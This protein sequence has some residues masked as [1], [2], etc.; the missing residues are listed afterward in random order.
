MGDVV[1]IRPP[2]CRCGWKLPMMPFNINMVG[3]I[4]SFEG[5]PI[6]ASISFRCPECQTPI[7]CGD[8]DMARLGEPNG[9]IR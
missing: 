2:R 3:G 7:Q 8:V 6:K 9:P 1:P 4:S 5:K